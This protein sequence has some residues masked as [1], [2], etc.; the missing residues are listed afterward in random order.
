MDGSAPSSAC[1]CSPWTCPHRGSAA[2][3]RNAYNRSA[4]WLIKP[5]TAPSR[6]TGR[7]PKQAP[8]DR[9]ELHRRC[10]TAHSSIRSRRRPTA[11]NCPSRRTAHQP[12]AAALHRRTAPSRRSSSASGSRPPTPRNATSRRTGSSAARRAASDR[13][14][15]QPFRVGQLITRIGHLTC[16][17][18]PA[19]GR[20]CLPVPTADACRMRRR[21]FVSARRTIPTGAAW[22]ARTGFLSV[23]VHLLLTMCQYAPAAGPPSREGS[24]WEVSR[25]GA[26]PRAGRMPW[27]CPPDLPP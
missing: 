14:E 20:V 26:G 7:Q 12:A 23:G 5:G 1:P 9:P 22:R 13:P 15:L 25:T 2:D 10:R 16:L 3:T 17:S 6:R 8:S 4:S 21:Q 24:Q 18:Y 11:R 27:R 19:A